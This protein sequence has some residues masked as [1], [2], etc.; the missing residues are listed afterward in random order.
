[1]ATIA[2]CHSRNR[3]VHTHIK[4]GASFHHLQSMTVCKGERDRW[5][6]YCMSHTVCIVLSLHAWLPMPTTTTAPWQLCVPKVVWVYT[7]NVSN[8]SQAKWETHNHQ[9][10]SSVKSDWSISLSYQLC[11]LRLNS[12]GSQSFTY[13]TPTAPPLFNSAPHPVFFSPTCLAFFPF[14]VCSWV[15]HF[16]VFSVSSNIFCFSLRCSLYFF[17]SLNT[18]YLNF[19]LIVWPIVS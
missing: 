18:F 17:L 5:V 15:H 7:A 16:P 6:T 10:I 4:T 2:Q 9:E 19:F 11:I 14:L 12:Q 8:V 13:L 1:M 3:D